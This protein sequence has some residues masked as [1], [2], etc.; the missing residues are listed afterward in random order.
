MK[1]IAVW[2][3]ISLHLVLLLVSYLNLG[4][5]GSKYML[6]DSGHAVFDFVAI[7]AKS[8][9]PVLSTQ[10]ARASK[11][12]THSDLKQT[13]NQ[14]S[15]T[16][17]QNNEPN[18]NN[19]KNDKKKDKTK[20]NKKADNNTSLKKS[21]KKKNKPTRVP[22]KTNDKKQNRSSDKATK[23]KRANKALVNMNDNKKKIV[24]NKKGIKS[25]FDS[26]IDNALADGETENSGM[27]AEEIGDTLTATQIDLVRETIRPCWHFPAG[28]KD[29]DQLVVDIQM[30]LNEDG[31]VKSA[32]I[33]DKARMTHDTGFRTAAESALRAVL[34]PACN[35][36]PLPKE[37][38]KEWRNLELSFNPK[39]WT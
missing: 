20:D 26:V 15:S 35:P 25:S 30:E 24:D 31:Y 39:D 1:P 19:Q 22:A 14:E 2:L 4:N 33:V 5:L 28:L 29:A 27:N 8:K 21:D 17:S 7:G 32:S 23:P 11:N 9:A 18:K 36:L 3:S 34:D 13:D 12:K 38:Y 6:K 10:S 37:K 16:H